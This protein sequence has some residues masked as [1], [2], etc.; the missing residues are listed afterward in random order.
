MHVEFIADSG[1][2]EHFVNKSFILSNFKIS[3]NG[4]IKSIN[5][6]EFA[7]IVIDGRD[8]LL[9]K[10]KS[11]KGT[12]IKL[13]NVFAAKD[14]SEN[15]L[16]LRK[17]VDAGFTIHLGDKIFRVYD[18]E[19]N[20]TIL[21]GKYEKPNWVVRF[22][23]VKT[24]DTYNCNVKECDNYSC[25]AF[26]ATDNEFLEQS[27]KNNNDLH[28]SS[29]EGGSAIGREKITELND[30]NKNNEN[31]EGKSK[32]SNDILLSHKIINIDDLKE[33]DSLKGIDLENT[34]ENSEVGKEQSEGMLWHL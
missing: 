20:K 29:S 32:E 27:Q 8:N 22:E 6:N 3:K 19:N 30:K 7:D 34:S 15:L 21:E 2:T 4:V 31:T 16:S 14:I 12:N 9:L 26:I 17:L 5:K 11:L 28:L 33:I 25:T 23:V 24:L 13:T 10:N 18:Q 1:A